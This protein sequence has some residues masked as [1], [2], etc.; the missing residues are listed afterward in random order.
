MFLLLAHKDLMIQ[1]AKCHKEISVWYER[2][3]KKFF[4]SKDLDFLSYF[5]PLLD[6]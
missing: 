2:I 1:I 4:K 5:H 6:G 3:K